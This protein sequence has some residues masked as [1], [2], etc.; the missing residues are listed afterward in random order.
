MRPYYEHGGITIYHADCREVLRG[1]DLPA[2]GG[3]DAPVLVTDPPYALN[4]TFGVSDLY[5]RRAMQFDMD[6]EGAVIGEVLES[7]DMAFGVTNAFHVFCA[8]EHYG[9]IAEKA[10]AHKFTPKPFARL[11]LCPPPPMPGNWWPSAFEVAMYGYRTG[12]WFGDQSGKRK[13][14]YVADSYREG[15]RKQEKVDHPTQ[16]WLPMVQYIVGSI[17]HPTSTVI[18]PFM[19]SG[20]TLRAAK[21]LGRRAIGIEIEERYCEMA[22]KRLGQEVMAWDEAGN[23]L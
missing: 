23:V 14:T 22:A 18:D 15:I 8:I 19:G 20:T 1:F 9:K 3:K 11:K 2:L 6:K 21:D 10:R 4:D 12:A 13:N 7:L 5:G 16:K 17:A